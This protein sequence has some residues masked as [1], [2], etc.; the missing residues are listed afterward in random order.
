MNDAEHL[1]T[2]H[3]RWNTPDTVILDA[4][5]AVTR[6]PVVSR[7]RIVHGAANEVY[8]FALDG[9]PSLIV[10][11]ARDAAKNMEP[12]RWTIA[13]CVSRGIAVPHIHDI[14]HVTVEGQPLH[15][16]V[17]AKIEGERLCDAQLTQAETHSV[18]NQLGEWLS[19]LH[20]VPVYGF[21]YLDGEG[22]APFK[23]Y[24]G[25]SDWFATV[26]P[27]FE[28]AA[29]AAGIAIA[30]LDAWL[31][32]IDDVLRA[33]RPAPVLCHNDLL[34]KHVLVREGRLAGV[35]D[36]G[37]VSGEPA[38]NEFAKWDFCDGERF[39]VRWLAEGYA[40][41]SLFAPGHEAFYR[42]LWLMNALYLL[43]WYHR[44]GH[45]GGVRDTKA[46]LFAGE[47]RAASGMTL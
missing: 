1:R 23:D 29:G 43:S 5:H 32:G 18:L 22:R 15:I 42:A 7:T 19:Q 11:I 20:T 33:V 46:K 41:Q 26:R 16:C 17:M 27:D 38:L 12:E 44:T 36:F 47:R 39:P 3:D 8:E 34:A 21:S 30:T 45:P 35:I 4:V 24:A 2:F 13:Q 6:A 10:R 25:T 40:D 14:Q 9:A 28:A 37:E 31:A